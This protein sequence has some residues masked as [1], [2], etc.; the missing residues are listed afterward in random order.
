MA[1]WTAGVFMAA[2]FAVTLVPVLMNGALPGWMVARVPSLSA[3]TP[4]LAFG[5]FVAGSAIVAMVS[6]A[7]A[8]FIPQ[9]RQ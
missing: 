7:L 3:A 4:G 9:R 5:V 6:F 8:R 1:I 2:I